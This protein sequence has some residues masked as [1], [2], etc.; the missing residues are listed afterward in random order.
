MAWSRLHGPV[1]NVNIVTTTVYLFRMAV[2]R[3]LRFVLSIIRCICGIK[4]SLTYKF[5]V[6]LLFLD[7]QFDIKRLHSTKENLYLISDHPTHTCMGTDYFEDVRCNVIVID[8][9]DRRIAKKY[10]W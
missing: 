3:G 1:R 2:V 8:D 6:Q 9:T 7:N 5:N 4:I 10:C